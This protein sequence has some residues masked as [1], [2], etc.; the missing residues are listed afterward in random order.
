MHVNISKHHFPDPS[1]GDHR[2]VRGG[3][4]QGW[5]SDEERGDDEAK[6]PS[7]PADRDQVLALHTDASRRRFFR[8]QPHSHFC[9]DGDRC[10]SSE[11]SEPDAVP[12]LHKDSSLLHG[13]GSED[14]YPVPSA[15]KGRDAEERAGGGGGHQ[16]N[17]V[18]IGSGIEFDSPITN[19]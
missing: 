11:G 6:R 18:N 1:L 3:G 19:R 4:W 2:V 13:P 7:I 16:T 8:C 5:H 17:D 15:G 10:L 14:K 9:L 12:V